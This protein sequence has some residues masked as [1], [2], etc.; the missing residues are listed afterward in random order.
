MDDKKH[1]EIADSLRASRLWI[2]EYANQYYGEW[3]AVKDG[4][5]LASDNNIDGLY[6]KI[7][8]EELSVDTI[9]TRVFY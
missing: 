2:S 5:L 1:K 3:I 4:K 6:K 8:E 9:I 7:D